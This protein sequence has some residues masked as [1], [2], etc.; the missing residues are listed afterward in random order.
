M[1][2]GHAYYELTPDDPT[3]GVQR[4][5]FDIPYVGP[6]LDWLVTGDMPCAMPFGATPD[7]LAD[8]TELSTSPG[9]DPMHID[10]HRAGSS[11][12]S[13]YARDDASGALRMSAYNLAAVLSGMQNAPKTGN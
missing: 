12:H 7:E 9:S 10:D 8:V 11:G 4:P 6:A 13:E 5:L 3:K 2:G 1:P